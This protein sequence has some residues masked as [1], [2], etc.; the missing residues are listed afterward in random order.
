MGP[1]SFNL[2]RLTFIATQLNVRTLG[3]K[4]LHSHGPLSSLSY[5]SQPASRSGC[6]TLKLKEEPLRF[7]FPNAPHSEVYVMEAR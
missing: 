7:F 5:Q 6:D 2:G 3:I 4:R 1:A